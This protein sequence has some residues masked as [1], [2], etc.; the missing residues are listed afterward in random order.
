MLHP[1][2]VPGAEVP[3]REIVRE[4]RTREGAFLYSL[5]R[6]MVACTPEIEKSRGKGDEIQDSDAVASP[7]RAHLTA[8]AVFKS[9]SKEPRRESGSQ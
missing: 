3:G 1:L 4:I 9:R 6:R 2:A 5:V 8:D 7:C